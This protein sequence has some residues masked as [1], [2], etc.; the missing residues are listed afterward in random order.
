VERLVRVGAFAAVS[1]VFLVWAMPSF[2][3]DSGTVN[4]RVSVAAPC[5]TATVT[6]PSA[7][8]LDFGSQSF[9]TPAQP[10]GTSLNDAVSIT[11]CGSGSENVLVRGTDATTTTS[12][13][14][15]QLQSTDATCS[16]G[17]NKYFVNTTI[18]D[19]NG[20]KVYPATTLTT[21]NQLLANI[22]T[23]SRSVTPLMIMPCSGST[24]AGDSMSFDIVFTASL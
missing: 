3:A 15:W 2:S 9:T 20:Q 23:G 17:A 11:N 19:A 13:A 12:S 16:V 14:A 21:A 4:A 18:R 24:G 22:G 6:W 7:P 8:T 1:A 5:L 10:G